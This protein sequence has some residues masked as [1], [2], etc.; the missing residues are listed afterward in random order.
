[1][2]SSARRLTSSYLVGIIGKPN[3]GKSTFFNAATLLNAATGSYPFTTIRPNIGIGY[4]RVRCV[5]KELNVTDNPVNSQC[6]DGVR[7]IPVSLVDVAGL[8]KGAS[9][10]RGLGN[11]FL[12]DLRQADAFI[13]V[14][15]ASESTDSEGK[16]CEP[17]K[18]DVLADVQMVEDELD[19]WI[20]DILKRDWVKISRQVEARELK[21]VEELS[22][23]L[24]GLGITDTQ[25]SSAINTLELSM[26]KPSSWPEGSLERVAKKLR[27]ISKPSLVAAN[28]ID[29]PSSTN[30]VEKLKKSGRL[31]VPCAA[32]AELLLRRAAQKGYISYLPGDKEFK[33]LRPDALLEKQREALRLVKEKVL[34]KWGGLGVQEAINASYLSLL[35]SFVVY[36]VEDETHLSDKKGRVLPD[37]YI[38]PRGSTAQDLAYRIHSDL[39]QTFLYAVEV[40]SGR[41]IGA[42]QELKDRDVVKIVATAKTG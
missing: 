17:G 16:P 42:K 5:C 21:L 24:S 36:P 10:G 30:G 40:R 6:I 4:I 3:T 12:D 19:A 1:M 41:R 32:E 33:I 22:K 8:V 7:L 23:R 11:K 29:L 39:G 25:I 27:E 2:A 13:H 34:D 20:T 35:G 31:V 28:K 9:M 14:V 26:S 37:A 18:G 15:D 38:M